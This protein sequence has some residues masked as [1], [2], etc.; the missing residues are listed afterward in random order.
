MQKDEKHEK[1]NTL[2]TISTGH[3]SQTDAVHHSIANP[4]SQCSCGRCYTTGQTA[5]AYQSCKVY[6]NKWQQVMVRC[7]NLL[8]KS[9]DSAHFLQ[10]LIPDPMSCPRKGLKYFR[11]FPSCGLLGWPSTTAETLSPAKQLLVWTPGKLWL[12]YGKTVCHY[13]L[14]RCININ[15]Q[16]SKVNW[17]GFFTFWF[18]F[19]Q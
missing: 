18:V 13:S 7:K 15:S 17:D 3:G 14:H 8:T 10:V 9:P 6:F 4:T 5:L 16:N 2:P 1:Y 11:V 12:S 19:L